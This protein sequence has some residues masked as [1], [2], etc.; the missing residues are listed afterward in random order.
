[1]VKLTW[2]TLV[3]RCAGT[4]DFDTHLVVAVDALYKFPYPLKECNDVAAGDVLSVQFLV[5]PDIKYLAFLSS[6]TSPASS[7]T[8]AGW[9]SD[10]QIDAALIYS[11]ANTN[12]LTV[13][14]ESIDL[15]VYPTFIDHSE[16][17]ELPADRADFYRKYIVKTKFF[18]SLE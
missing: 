7:C 9:C 14:S 16:V 17:P 5:V 6:R 12:R 2:P 13:T 1:M 18:I 15:L 4:F 3:D 8:P 11:H 10:N